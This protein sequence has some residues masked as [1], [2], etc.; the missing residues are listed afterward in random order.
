MRTGKLFLCAAIGMLLGCSVAAQQRIS[1]LGDSYSTFGGHVS[2]ASNLC[3]YN[4]N[5]GS[6]EKKNDVSRVEETWWHLLT[7]LSQY[8]L[9]RNNSYS[10]STVCCTG[11]K[12]QDY[13]D[14][15]FVTRICNLGNPD[16]ILVFGGT[17]DSWA[18]VPVGEYRYEGWDKEALC[19]FRPAF[20]YLLASLQQL[21][22]QAKILNITNSELSEEVTTSMMEICRHYQV[23][24]VLLHDV[25]KQ[26]GHPSVKG[27]RSIYDQVSKALT[28]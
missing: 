13:S 1:I 4:S 10:G 18:G 6:A 15:A 27:M 14:R 16:I 25:E 12:Q 19:S 22:P 8:Q 3:W 2:P 20:A 7:S 9:E 17:N 24:N 11:Y 23:G 5:D 26:W 21:Y 28:E